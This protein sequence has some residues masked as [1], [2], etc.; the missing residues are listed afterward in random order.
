MMRIGSEVSRKHVQRLLCTALALT[1]FAAPQW[2]RAQAAVRVVAPVDNAQ[3]TTLH[4]GTPALV[5]RSFD[6][7]RLA[8]SA[9]ASQMVLVLQRSAAQQAQLDQAL[10]ELQSKSSPNYHKWLKPEEFSKRFGIA[11]ADMAAVTS[12]LTSQG[13]SITK[14][15]KGHTAI[16]FSGT[17]GQVRTAFHTELHT[18]V[19]PD[20]TT[21]HANNSDPQI[22]TALSSVVAGVAALNNIPAMAFSHTVGTVAYNAS[23]HSAKPTANTQASPEWTYPVSTGGV[24][25][26][27][28]PGDLA[29][30]Y[31]INP[32][33]AAGNTG[34]GETIGIVSQAGVN[35]TTI[36]NYRKLFGLSATNLPTVVVDGYDPGI[37]G[38]GAGI[39]ADL[40]VEVSGSTA[41]NASQILYTGYDTQVSLGLFNAAV[42]AVDDNT[43]DIISMS[44][45]ICEPTLGLAGNLLFNQLWAQ[46]AAQG[47]TVIV[48][49]G[50]SGSA[51]CDN[52]SASAT[53]GLAVNGITS[54]PYNLSV[55]GTDFYYG[56]YGSSGESAAIDSYWNKTG[57]ASPTTSLL[58]TIP[59]QPWN[60]AFGFNAA[61]PFTT[62]TT[63][64]G[65]GGPSN[66]V[67]GVSAPPNGTYSDSYTSCSAGTP[68]PAWQKAPG[69]PSDGVRDIPDIALFAA[70]GFNYSFYPICAEPGDC[71]ASTADPTTGE[72]QITGVGGTSASA[73]LMAGIMAL[74]D[75][76]QHGRQG[77]PNFVL[78]SLANSTPSVFHDVTV[79][80]NNVNCTQGTLNCALDTN[81]FYSYS[82]YAAGTGYDLASGL[83][84]IDANALLTN[85]TKPTFATTT[86]TLSASSLSFAHG[87]PVTLASVVSSASGTP[88]GA[89]SLVSTSTASTQS[90]IGTLNLTGGTAEG[91]LTDLPAGTYQLFAHYGG[92]GT[93]AASVSDPISLTVT[94]E[95]AAIAISGVYF[96]VTSTGDTAAAAPITNNLTTAYGSFFDIDAK[97]FGASSTAANPD[98]IATGTI[99]IYDSGKLLTTLNLSDNGLAEFQTGSLGAGMHSLTFAYSGDGSFNAA[100]STPLSLTITQ[101]PAQILISYSIPAGL[102][103]GGTLTV[104]VEVTSAAGQLPLTGSVTVTFGSQTQTIQTLQQSDFGG[105]SSL[106]YG[107]VTFDISKPGS[108]NLNATYSGDA[109]L[110]TASAFNPSTVTIYTSTLQT[111]TTTIT[112]SANTIGPDTSTLT[113]TI[114]VTGGATPPTGYVNVFQNANYFQI[115]ESLDATGTVVVPIPTSMILGN[116]T[117]D[118]TA[119]YGGDNYNSPSV[120]APATVTSNIGDYLLATSQAAVSMSAGASGTTMISVGAPYG[121]RLSGAVTLTCATSSPVL[122]CSLAQ[123]SLTLPSDPDMV[124][125]T[126][127]TITSQQGTLA[128]LTAPQRFGGTGTV[129]AASGTLFGLALLVLPRRRRKFIPALLGCVSLLA[130]MLPMAGCNHT[131]TVNQLSPVNTTSSNAGTYTVTVT[132]AS[133]GITKTL[134]IRVV[135]K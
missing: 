52:G 7:G 126:T 43:A 57:S 23:T 36:A 63:S 123:S 27:T 99:T 47:Q 10:A 122:G 135:L 105:L 49:S 22:P 131:Y 55:G 44:Y 81:G 132:A 109:N 120:S 83:G 85:W 66:C 8:D 14:L 20:G 119:S 17:V 128:S 112:M 125:N 113:A 129:L 87:T 118:F 117:I 12:W 32:I 88:T 95:N 134:G 80:S 19:A 25:L 114:K 29:V 13:F 11:D 39:E 89:V 58:K 70:N 9:P 96:G 3:R 18:Y 102:P 1:S 45:G 116:G 103:A 21:F 108:Y 34:T 48:S 15:A 72:M 73:P 133:A 24:Y 107:T 78:Y 86:T 115:L 100:T 38:D 90:S 56:A 77:N 50:D 68:K 42:R 31:D 79:G 98:G 59:E 16:E 62:G 61:S 64:A 28:A 93:Y 97:V 82:E 94:P 104:P 40:D 127:L 5:S 51:G 124:A 121:L 26:M 69:V 110:T 54:T 60:N 74:I 46:A 6:Q 65:S 53:H 33:Y 130:I 75:Q 4:G 35:N 41:P 37:D 91:T 84:S 106:G 111:T 67:S 76:S 92:D 2:M 30:Q 101:S 71:E